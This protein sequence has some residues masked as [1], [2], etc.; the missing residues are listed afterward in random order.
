MGVNVLTLNKY[1]IRN[2]T[3]FTITM[4]HFEKND[5]AMKKDFNWLALHSVVQIKLQPHFKAPT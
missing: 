4:F 1:M 5:E 3:V 2:Y